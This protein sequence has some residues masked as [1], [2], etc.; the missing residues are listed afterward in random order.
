L[1][2]CLLPVAGA[3]DETVKAAAEAAAAAEKL[4]EDADQAVRVRVP[5]TSK[6]QAV[7]GFVVMVRTG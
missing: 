6:L 1:L 3:I 2:A 7:V 5:I 4:K